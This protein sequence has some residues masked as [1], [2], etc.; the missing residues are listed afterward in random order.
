METLTIRYF[1][2]IFKNTD[3]FFIYIYFLF[4]LEFCYILKHLPLC[5]FKVVVLSSLNYWAFFNESVNIQVFQLCV[6]GCSA[7]FPFVIAV[8]RSKYDLH[9]LKGWLRMMSIESE[10]GSGR[11]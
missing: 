9:K 11:R 7:N 6:L 3:T 4:A 10:R 5:L 1:L 8:A 2:G